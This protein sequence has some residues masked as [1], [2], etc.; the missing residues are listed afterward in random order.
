MYARYHTTIFDFS[1]KC[2]IISNIV[3]FV[4]Y[5][6]KLFVFNIDFVRSPAHEFA[7]H[8]TCFIIFFFIL[9]LVY[10]F[11]G[12]NGIETGPYSKNGTKNVPFK[13]CPNNGT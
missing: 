12:S 13:V 10:N 1:S 2:I 5:I 7:V 11:Y 6:G 8:M 3:D 4:L 9:L